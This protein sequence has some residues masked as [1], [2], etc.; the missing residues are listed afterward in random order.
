M[1]NELIER[2]EFLSSLQMKFES[3][4]EGEG[5]CV[6]LSGEAGIGKTSLIKVFCQEKKNDCKILSVTR[7]SY[8]KGSNNSTIK[9]T[10]WQLLRCY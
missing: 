8:T 6:L 4:A 3:V 9:T 5:H 1:N 7:G 2:A 10:L